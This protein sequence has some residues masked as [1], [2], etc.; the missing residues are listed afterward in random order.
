MARTTSNS[1]MTIGL[2]VDGLR[3]DAT[4]AIADDSPRH[5]IAELAD[6]VRSWASERPVLLVAEDHRNLAEIVK[7]GADGWGCDAVWSDDFH[8]GVRRI[9]AGDRDGQYM[10]FSDS[11]SELAV[12]VD[13]GWCHV[14]QPSAF[15]GQPRG[16]DP[17]GVAPEHIVIFL[18]NHDQVG[19]QPSGERLHH[20]IDL[21]EFRALSVVLLCAPETPLLFMGQEWAATTPFL[22][23]TDHEPE[24]GTL[25]TSER[26]RQFAAFSGFRQDEVR[27]RIPDPQSVSTFEAS[28][29]IWDERRLPPH[30]GTFALYQALL[31]LRRSHAALEP[32]SSC[33]SAAPD[34]HTLVVKRQALSGAALL[35]VACLRDGGTVDLQ[36]WIGSSAQRPWTVIL[37]SEDPSFLPPADRERLTRLPIARYG[38][39]A[40][41]DFP[42]PSAV[43]LQSS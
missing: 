17:V 12:T 6:Q 26:L 23:F 11:A 18:Q 38:R 30:A 10:D 25:I 1:A 34:A 4:H 16:S 29:L 24:L 41:I 36:Q 37:N 43:V 35:I 21:A 8:H 19:N 40:A 5:F 9:V 2:N 14:G 39:G 3:L 27:A 32:P 22:F 31:R 15:L 28:R 20:Q 7:P 33:E 13:R 42:R